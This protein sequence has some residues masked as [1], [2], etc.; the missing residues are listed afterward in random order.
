MLE[1]G[2]IKR[3]ESLP[4]HWL[5]GSDGQNI[6]SR[7]PMVGIGREEKRRQSVTWPSR[8]NNYELS[9]LGTKAC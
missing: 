8:Y 6:E 9:M 4:M 1:L 3:M 7:F 5:E 2:R